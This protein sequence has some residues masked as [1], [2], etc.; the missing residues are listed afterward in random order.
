MSALKV[1]TQGTVPDGWKRVSFASLALHEPGCFDEPCDCD[2]ICSVCGQPYAECPCPGPT[3]D[4]E[5]Y[6]LEVGGV[7]YARR[8]PLVP[9]GAGRRET[10]GDGRRGLSRR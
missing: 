2:V 10:K 9:K 4:D 5:Y 3:Q 7:M 8:K 1:A 6:Y